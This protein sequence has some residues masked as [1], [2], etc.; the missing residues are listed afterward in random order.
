ML[1]MIH[2]AHIYNELTL[3]KKR[4]KKL[5]EFAILGMTFIH[6]K[7]NGLTKWGFEVK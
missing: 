4:L 1:V 7:K 6:A 3:S 2:W 5:I